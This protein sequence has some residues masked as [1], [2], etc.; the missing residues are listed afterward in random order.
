ML[1]QG[2][3]IL[4]IDNISLRGKTINEINQ[5][6]HTN[7]EVVK[8]KIKKDELYTDDY[9]ADKL[10]VY[11]VEMHRNGGPLGI[12]ISG[13]D[14]LYEPMFVSGLTE[15]G[16]AERTNAIHPGD[17]I[18]AINNVSL[19]GKSLSEAIEL[20]QT[21]DSDIVTLKISRK[22][23]DN[24]NN[25]NSTSNGE[26]V[27]NPKDIQQSL[28]SHQAYRIPIG[29]N[30][31]NNDLINNK[32]NNLNDD[33][34]NRTRQYCKSFRILAKKVIFSFCFCFFFEGSSKY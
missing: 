12:T 25:N 20:L 21:A 3:Q 19:R 23:V 16:L 30:S 29:G 8:L 24:N 15:G 27:I 18:L 5:L 10:V 32:N 2:D 31:L 34:I 1:Q 6:L 22:F 4:F 7:E 28:S 13:S 9:P 26:C 11:T 14:D 33:S 17:I